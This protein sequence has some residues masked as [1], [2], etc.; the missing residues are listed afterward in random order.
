[1]EINQTKNVKAKM[2]GRKLK[3]VNW[4]ESLK[5]RPETN[6]CKKAFLCFLAS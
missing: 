2:S 6:V 5:Q 4:Y 3:C 1:M